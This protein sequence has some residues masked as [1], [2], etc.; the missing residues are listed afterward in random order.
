LTL[1]RVIV[2]QRSTAVAKNSRGTHFAGLCHAHA[3]PDTTW[4]FRHLPGGRGFCPTALSPGPTLQLSRRTGPARTVHPH[5]SQRDGRL[6]RIP[7]S[8]GTFLVFPC[9]S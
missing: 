3:Y 9:V 4:T 1:C 7:E 8:C 6:F 5:R 2:Q